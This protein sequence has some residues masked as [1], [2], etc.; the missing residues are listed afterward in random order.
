MYLHPVYSKVS[1]DPWMLLFFAGIFFGLAQLSAVL[2][3]GTVVGFIFFIAGLWKLGKWQ[4][5]TLGGLLVGTFKSLGG[6]AWIWHAY[7]LVWLNVDSALLQ[8]LLIGL[9]WLTTSVFMGVGIVL[10]ALLMWYLRSRTWV[11][12]LIF[13]V[14]WLVG[15]VLG[16]FFVSLWLLGPGSYINIY[17][18]HGYAGLPLAQFDWLLS[19]MSLGGLYGLTYFSA[20]TGVLLSLLVLKRE[21]IFGVGVLMLVVLIVLLNTFIPPAK[22]KPLNLKVIT[23]NTTFSA[24]SQKTP[25]GRAIK[26]EEMINAVIEAAKHEP[27]IILLPED[28]RLGSPYADLNGL[29][30]HLRAL[31]PEFNGVIVDTARVE[32]GANAVLRAFYH[33]LGTDK[34]YVTDKQFLVP[35][36]EYVTHPF[37]FFLRLMG[38]K[39]IV[40]ETNLNQNYVPGPV[41]GYKNFPSNIPPIIFC[42]ESSSILGIQRVN[43][44]NNIPLV[45]H[46]VSHSWF[47]NPSILDYQLGAMLKIQSVWNNVTVITASNMSDS[48]L[49]LPDGTTEV[50]RILIEDGLW[51]LSEYEI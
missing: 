3:V 37:K 47:T 20:L 40:A 16:S 23:V 45:L 4:H 11:M 14:A 43:R 12:V 28:S 25:S 9:Y 22:N 10:P 24:E 44:Q 15:E 21:K 41:T 13:P 30:E 5:V 32:L 2:W 29:R 38:Q 19:V 48:R 17:I 33:D 35:Q 50:G 27:D 46:P 42:F 8:F 31:M 7:P 39:E 1:R 6:F 36:G 51:S 18:G 26:Q 49:H 34:T